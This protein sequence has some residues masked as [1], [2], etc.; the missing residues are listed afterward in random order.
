VMGVLLVWFVKNKASEKRVER[1]PIILAW[2]R[3]GTFNPR[4]HNILL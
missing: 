2:A 1:E 4:G 3:I